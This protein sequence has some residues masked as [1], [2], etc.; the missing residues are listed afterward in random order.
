M[1]EGEG[2]EGFS[3]I[4]GIFTFDQS[5]VNLL[6]SI[7][8]LFFLFDSF[9]LQSRLWIKHAHTLFIFYAYMIRSFAFSL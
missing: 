7:F 6:V 1:S 5:R 9:C 4:F 3:C 2:E 8:S